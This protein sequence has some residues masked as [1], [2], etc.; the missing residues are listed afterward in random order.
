[1]HINKKILVAVCMLSGV[2]LLASMTL[3]Q[4]QQPQQQQPQQQAQQPQAPRKFTNLK[5]LPKHIKEKD[6][7][8]YM[9]LFAT[10]LGVRCNFCHATNAET[11]KVDYASDAKPEK[12]MARHML[13]MVE[14]I[15]KKY[16]KAEKDSM[17]MVKM[18]KINCYTCHRGTAH[19]EV[20]VPPRVAPGGGQ[21]GQGGPGGQR[22][23]GQGGQGGQT[24]PPGTTTPPAGQK[25][26]GYIPSSTTAKK[27]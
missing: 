11:K 19:L 24:P 3:V 2:V 20:M 22:P 10:S 18:S 7:D 25:P 1:M 9:R 5:V 27:V 4:Q 13:L 23:G 26:T 15:N 6:L 17:G 8:N 12:T 16:F 21:G 14:K